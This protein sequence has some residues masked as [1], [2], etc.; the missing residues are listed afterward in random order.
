V[1][2]ERFPKL[3]MPSPRHLVA[4]KAALS[5]V[6]NFPAQV[7]A[8]LDALRS[9]G[10]RDTVAAV[11]THRTLLRKEGVVDER[12]LWALAPKVDVERLPGS[13]VMEKWLRKR[14]DAISE[15]RA[16]RGAFA[17]YLAIYPPNRL[18]ELRGGRASF[19]LVEVERGWRP[20]CYTTGQVRWPYAADPGIRRVVEDVDGEYWGKSYE[21]KAK[22]SYRR[23]AARL[24]EL[25]AQRWAI[26]ADPPVL[27]RAL[28]RLN[29]RREFK[30]E[31]A[32]PAQEKLL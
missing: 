19:R 12:N 21:C 1:S 31:P 11:A 16:A 29:R 17:Y 18:T 22:I 25:E 6:G 20:G 32:G 27:E 24:V 14:L 13:T 28:D 8:G 15:R 5:C 2:H 10:Y 7:R 26:S 9:E 4:L 30:L 23:L 3:D